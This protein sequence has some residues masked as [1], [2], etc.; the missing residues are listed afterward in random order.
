[1]AGQHHDR[2]VRPRRLAAHPR[3]QRA[4]LAPEQRLLG[5]EQRCRAP[6]QLVQQPVEIGAQLHR[7]P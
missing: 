4:E 6:R 2:Q 3:L 7:Q 5:H 1:M